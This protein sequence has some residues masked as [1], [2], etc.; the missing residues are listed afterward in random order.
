M[1]SVSRKIHRHII[2]RKQP[3]QNVKQD[4]ETPKQAAK[5]QQQAVNIPK[6][7]QTHRD[8]VHYVAKGASACFLVIFEWRNHRRC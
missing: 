2:I 3:L 1:M 6:Q 5:T 7:P 8:R 4:V